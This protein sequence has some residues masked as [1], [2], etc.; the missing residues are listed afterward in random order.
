MKKLNQNGFSWVEGLLILVIIVMIGGVGWKVYDSTKKTD[1]TLNKANSNS[2]ASTTNTLPAGFMSYENK[3]L[4]FKFNYPK[5]WGDVK[6]EDNADAINKA[7]EIGSRQIITFSH[8]SKVD[9]VVISPSWKLGPNAYTDTPQQPLAGHECYAY[10]PV[11]FSIPTKL[12]TGIYQNER[13]LEKASNYYIT[14]SISKGQCGGFII[15][16]DKKAIS[17]KKISTI[18]FEYVDKTPQNW[19]PDEL[20]KQVKKY[21]TNHNILISDTDRQQVITFF[22]SIT[23]L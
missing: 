20:E 21:N 13:F 9:V 8:Q 23:D 17:N 3:D 18:G 16:G 15:N 7:R 22:K 2:F 5:E 19:T 11:S 6:V 12:A 14:E 1:D 10:T 4:A